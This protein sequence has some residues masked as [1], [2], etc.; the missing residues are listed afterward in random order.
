MGKNFVFT[1]GVMSG[2][3]TP[4]RAAW[5]MIQFVFPLLKRDGITIKQFAEKVPP[6]NLIGLIR[7]IAKE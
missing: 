1:P 3:V 7:L 6:E 4:Q 2:G 5:F